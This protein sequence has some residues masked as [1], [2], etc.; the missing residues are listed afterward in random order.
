MDKSPEQ[1]TSL[2]RYFLQCVQWPWAHWKNV[3]NV[4]AI[5]APVSAAL[6]VTGILAAIADR[7]FT[8]TALAVAGSAAAV[9]LFLVLFVAPYALWRRERIRASIA[10]A[11]LIPAIEVEG[12]IRP[13]ELGAQIACIQ[14]RNRS[15]AGGAI[16][17]CVG[18]LKGVFTLSAQG[19]LVPYRAEIPPFLFRWSERF[20]A[21][22]NNPKLTFTGAAELEVAV[23]RCDGGG[24]R[25]SIRLLTFHPETTQFGGRLTVSKD[26]YLSEN[27]C[28]VL[29]VEVSAENTAT[30]RGYFRLNIEFPA[31]EERGYVNEFGTVVI[32]KPAKIVA[33]SAYPTVPST[34]VF[35]DAPWGVLPLP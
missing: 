17:G 4:W 24:K 1:S 14:V 22:A 31:S 19:G 7:F 23:A 13:A 32:G 27:T 18:T 5:V 21:D 33:F 3:K 2:G 26:R 29:D 20:Q 12:V 28:Y 15:G 11:S 8:D 30:V 6:G 9:Y 25:C 34:Q 35:A 16:V 10:E